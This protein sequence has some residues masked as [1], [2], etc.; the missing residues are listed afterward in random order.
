MNGKSFTTISP[1]ILKDL[2]RRQG[3]MIQD[4]NSTFKSKL[5]KKGESPVEAKLYESHMTISYR[6]LW[7]SIGIAILSEYQGLLKIKAPDTRHTFFKQQSTEQK[8]IRNEDYIVNFRKC[9]KV[10]KQIYVFE[11]AEFSNLQGYLHSIKKN[12]V[13]T[14]VPK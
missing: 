14:H 9:S 6:H 3:R 5:S 2:L 12:F 10:A 7:V 4:D 1:I 8:I 13:G 11:K